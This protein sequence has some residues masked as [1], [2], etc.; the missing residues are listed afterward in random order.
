M[1]TAGE[2]G[3]TRAPDAKLASLLLTATITTFALLAILLLRA[4]VQRGWLQRA[5][6]AGLAVAALGAGCH[7]TVRGYANLVPPPQPEPRRE[8]APGIVYERRVEPAV[9]RVE[10]WARVSIE[11]VEVVIT[12]GDDEEL[13]L[14]GQTTSGFAEREGLTLAINGGFFDPWEAGL[15][16]PY[17]KEG[18]RVAPLG[19][20]ASRGHVYGRVAPNTST[21]YVNEDGSVSFDEP[22]QVWGALSGGCMLVSRGRRADA[23]GCPLPKLNDKRH[24]RTAVGLTEDRRTLILLV[25]D[26]RQRRRSAGATL[27][28]LADLLVAEGAHEAVNFDGGG[29]SVLVA[30]GASGGVEVLSTPI[31]GGVPGNERVVGSHLGVRPR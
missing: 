21:L 15:L 29:S 30:R 20:A 2:R 5:G 7:T 1:T 16:D 18:E 6:I 3:R 24:P 14:V 17:P 13:P 11:D 10:H 4:R 8:I 31:S 28:E 9:P 26:G 12:E 19:F 22:A 25:V 23:N 27:D